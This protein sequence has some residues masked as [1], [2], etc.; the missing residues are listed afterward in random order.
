MTQPDFF[1]GHLPFWIVTYTLSVVGWTCLGR[2]LMSF[3]VQPDSTLYIWRA[4]RL[5]T[6]WA[7]HAVAVVTPRMVPPILL[8]PLAALWV[9]LVRAAA[10]LAML[11]AGMVPTLGVTAGG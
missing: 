10:S 11:A 1:L 8:A 3:F 5:L 2:F 4:F 9:F 6:D 7:V